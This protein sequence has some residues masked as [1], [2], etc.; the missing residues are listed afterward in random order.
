MR[1]YVFNL[2]STGKAICIQK[3]ISWSPHLIDRFPIHCR[4]D[5][6]ERVAMVG[7]GGYRTHSTYVLEMET[8]RLSRAFDSNQQSIKLCLKILI[9]AFELV[10]RFIYRF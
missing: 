9:Y 3:D 2:D 5:V 7:C 6:T 10:C 4:F 8:L 1:Q